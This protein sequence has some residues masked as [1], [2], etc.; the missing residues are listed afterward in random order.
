MKLINDDI[1]WTAP[2]SASHPR[3]DSTMPHNFPEIQPGGSLIVAWQV[4]GK[5][6]LVVG[7][8]EVS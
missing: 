1:R 4:R 3:P 8:G 2:L 5:R 6:I 7:G